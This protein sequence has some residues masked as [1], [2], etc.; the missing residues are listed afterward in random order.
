MSE[1]KGRL[2]V[3]NILMFGSAVS[4]YGANPILVNKKR[5][6]HVLPPYV[7]QHLTSHFSLPNPPQSKRHTC[8][9][10]K[11]LKEIPTKF[12]FPN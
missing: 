11:L 6:E 8:I 7:R 1:S 9:S 3:S 10:P 12:I 2:L 4:G 5:P